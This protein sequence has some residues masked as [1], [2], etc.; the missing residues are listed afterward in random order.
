MHYHPCTEKY[1][2]QSAGNWSSLPVK[3][4]TKLWKVV[5]KVCPLLHFQ[6]IGGRFP[7]KSRGND[8]LWQVLKLLK[9]LIR[10]SLD[11]PE[12]KQKQSNTLRPQSFMPTK[13]QANFGCIFF[14]NRNTEPHT[15]QMH[16]QAQTQLLKGSL[17]FKF[18]LVWVSSHI[19]F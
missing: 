13:G 7:N 11:D 14:T 16:G 10:K 2:Y 15:Q 3:C 5:V 18:G 6:I 4:K 9:Q 8:A 12:M 17:K 19:T 1:S